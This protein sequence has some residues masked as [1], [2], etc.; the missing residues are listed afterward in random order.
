MLESS[1]RRQS[2]NEASIVVGIP[3]CKGFVVQLD[4]GFGRS[5]MIVV[6]DS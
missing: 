6:F 3:F 1:L 2:S 4:N 5:A